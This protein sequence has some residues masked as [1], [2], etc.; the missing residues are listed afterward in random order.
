[1]RHETNVPSG[2]TRYDGLLHRDEKG[3]GKI[4]RYGETDIHR[5]FRNYAHSN[6]IH[7]TQTVRRLSVETNRSFYGEGLDGCKAL[8]VHQGSQCPY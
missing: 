7:C 2:L 1:M 3:G 4:E 8:I 5:T 6:Y